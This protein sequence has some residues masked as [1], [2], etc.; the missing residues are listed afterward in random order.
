MQ[1]HIREL[2]Y[3]PQKNRCFRLMQ[4][5]GMLLTFSED[6]RSAKKSLN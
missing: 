2:R 5:E 6:K 4:I 3:F 1:Q